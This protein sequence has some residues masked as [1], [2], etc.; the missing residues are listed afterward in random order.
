M[1]T[2]IR[3]VTGDATSPQADG[4]RIIAHVCNDTGTWGAGFVL[5]VSARWP[6]PEQEYRRWA[7]H[8]PHFELGRVQMVE[9]G[10]GTRVA[11]MIAQRA[12]IDA[13]AVPHL[14]RLPPIRYLAL[15]DR[16]EVRRLRAHAADRLRPGRRALG[17]GRAPRH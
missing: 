10:D 17:P 2:P 14:P 1:N 3:Y 13:P 6:E 8:G 5:A 7:Q 16:P 9:V 4:P 12:T 15:R 11:N